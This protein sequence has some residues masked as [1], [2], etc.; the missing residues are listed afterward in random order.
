MGDL[1]KL[2]NPAT[3]AVIGATDKEGTFGGPS[4]ITR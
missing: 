2:F 3:I 4:W 1:Q